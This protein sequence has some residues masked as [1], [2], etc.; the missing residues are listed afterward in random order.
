MFKMSYPKIAWYYTID[1]VNYI[2]NEKHQSANPRRCAYFLAHAYNVTI[3]RAHD[4]TGE[5]EERV[6]SANFGPGR[7]TRRTKFRMLG[8]AGNVASLLETA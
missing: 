3:P 1:K 6:T 2:L 8:C 7:T 4:K 5:E